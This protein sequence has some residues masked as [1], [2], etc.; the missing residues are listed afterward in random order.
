MSRLN[1]ITLFQ[2]LRRR[3]VFRVAVLYGVGAWGV[4]AGG[5]GLHPLAV[6]HFLDVKHG[7]MPG[8]RTA[9]S[10]AAGRRWHH[11]LAAR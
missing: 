11:F 4:I 1:P 10:A 5:R 2:E 7:S 6:E 9:Q 3:R 8:A